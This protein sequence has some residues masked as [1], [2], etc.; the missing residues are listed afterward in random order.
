MLVSLSPAH[1]C[2]LGGFFRT[3]T[4]VN[5]NQDPHNGP[6][7][8]DCVLLLFVQIRLSVWRRTGFLGSDMM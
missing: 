6:I 3:V 8:L 2:P 4:L 7:I 1:I 5:P